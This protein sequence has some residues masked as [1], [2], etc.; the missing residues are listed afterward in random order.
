MRLF[1]RE[2]VEP[3]PTIPGVPEPDRRKNPE[4]FWYVAL[5][6]LMAVV[7]IGVVT[8]AAAISPAFCTV[9]HS[10]SAES[11]AE[12]PHATTDCNTCHDRNG[13]LGIVESRLR[14]VSM[15]Y[16]APFVGVFGGAASDVM[17]DSD[18]C[19]EC[20]ETLI[21]KTISRY[22]IRMNHRA[23]H[24]EGWTCTQCHRGASHAGEVFSGA[25]YNMEMCLQ[26]HSAGPQNLTT[27]TTCHDENGESRENRPITPWAV[28]HGANWQSTHGMGDLNTCKTCHGPDYC[29][30]CHN[31][32]LP[33]QANFLG[34]HGATVLARE[35]GDRD[36]TVCHQGAACDNCH[37]IQM[38]HPA[39]FVTEHQAASQELGAVCE[40]CHAPEQCNQC[41]TRHTHPGIPPNQ[42]EL[43]QN[44]LVSV[45]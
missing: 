13:V 34:N 17:I 4:I 38:P 26:C 40:R 23:P 32:Q 3:S 1:R 45:R 27:C 41:H 5:S 14:V 39:D 42:L 15:V 33:H 16:R 31:M 36:C 44:N 10:G 30:A 19:V 37:G 25:S 20:H 12:S 28:T 2:P 35:T 43:L 24:V 6:V 29:V 22:G 11:L 8:T 9:C 18:N 7:L 21:P